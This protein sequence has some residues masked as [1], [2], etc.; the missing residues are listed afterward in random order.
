MKKMKKNLSLILIITSLTTSMFAQELTD[1]IAQQP[2][3]EKKLRGVQLGL[4]NLSFQYESR[5]ARKFTLLAEAG[6][7][8]GFSSIETPT[9]TTYYGLLLPYVTAEPR[10]Y[11]GLDRRIRKGKN[12]K[13]NGSNYLSLRT[14]YW[15]SDIPIINNAPYNVIPSLFIIP[16][17]GIRRNFAKNFNYEFSFG[18]GYQLNIFN[19]NSCPNCPVGVDSY[20]IQA[21]IGY[22]F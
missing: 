1:S 6:L 15:P 9:E 7:E 21:R 18:Y 20:D 13:N 8:L 5:L 3:V 22:N 12:I 17:F 2:S 19:A 14:T 11:Y 16:K 4:L 10:W